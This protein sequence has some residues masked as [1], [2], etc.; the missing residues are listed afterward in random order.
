[1]QKLTV[2]STVLVYLYLLNCTATYVALATC[3]VIIM[4]MLRWT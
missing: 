4:D 3:A 2:G 1:M